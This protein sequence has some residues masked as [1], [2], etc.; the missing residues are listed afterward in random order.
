[1]TSV[2]R[3]G[4]IL[5][6][7]AVH[8]L[9]MKSSKQGDSDANMEIV[10]EA[11]V[12]GCRAFVNFDAT[13]QD[14]GETA[15]ADGENVLIRSSGNVDHVERINIAAYKIYFEKYMSSWNYVITGMV[16]SGEL[17]TFVPDNDIKLKLGLTVK[18]NASDAVL[19]TAQRTDRHCIVYVTAENQT[20]GVH[21]LL[22]ANPPTD[23]Q[24]SIFGN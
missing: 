10:G 18:S 12:Y 14:D 2:S 21:A 3:S 1:M 13:L 19:S 22:A 9:K 5:K 6:S 20:S 7:G 16:G 17:K 23:I 15:A 11:P 8:D 24:V 4:Y